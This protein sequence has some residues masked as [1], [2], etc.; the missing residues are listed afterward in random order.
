MQESFGIIAREIDSWE[1]EESVSHA[2]ELTQKLNG[3]DKDKYPF[4]ITHKQHTNNP[5][6]ICKSPYNHAHIAWNGNVLFC[7]DFYDFS[8]GNVKE[9]KLETVFLN[10]KSE[11]FR[12][13]IGRNKCSTC[14]H[15]SWRMSITLHV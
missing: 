5:D 8:A 1:T 10:E 11:K 12:A 6:F 9:E 7:T 4:T 13:E 2:A 3:I 14:R 15:C